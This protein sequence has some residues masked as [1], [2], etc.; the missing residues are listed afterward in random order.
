[1]SRDFE[2]THD[3]EYRLYQISSEKSLNKQT[4]SAIIA[5]TTNP[6]EE[7]NLISRV[8]TEY[9]KCLVFNNTDKNYKT[10]KKKK[11]EKIQPYAWRDKSSQ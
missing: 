8:G 3:K 7:E 10:C 2:V 1:M 11:N 6:G 9:L 5:T 4:A